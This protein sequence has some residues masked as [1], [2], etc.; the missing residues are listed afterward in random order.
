LAQGK[1]GA[2]DTI[3]SACLAGM[4]LAFHV[5]QV[6]AEAGGGVPPPLQGWLLKQKSDAGRS[7]FFSG[8]NRRYFTLDY[9]AQQLVYAH[10]EKDV[11]DT[12]SV[13]FYS[14]VGVELMQGRDSAGVDTPAEE[15]DAD[16]ATSRLV[17]QSRAT[18]SSGFRMP[19]L[20]GLSKTKQENVG[21]RLTTRDKMFE[22]FAS[23]Q[24]EADTWIR[25]LQRAVA[26]GQ[27]R[28]YEPDSL[29]KVEV[30]APPQRSP[31]VSTIASLDND[32][33]SSSTAAGESSGHASSEGEAPP[34]RA[35]AGPRPS[36]A[37]AAE[38]T[39]RHPRARDAG[40]LARVQIAQANAGLSVADSRSQANGDT[41]EALGM[42]SASIEASAA[43]WQSP[44]KGASV[45]K[46]SAKYGD[47]FQGL[48]LKERLEQMDFSD[49]EEGD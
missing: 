35:R 22:L 38:A 33:A 6:P 31:T 34:A 25:G 11:K 4:A 20:R 9:A 24:E 13:P 41:V 12:V 29:Q 49:D 40:A 10:S 37:A 14:L 3:P 27:D 7:R 23:S 1:A 39:A 16:D 26:L 2:V 18:A 17:K 47:R 15:Q 21:I 8:T 46:E 42:E 19:R 32:Q 45:A 48:S 30:T 28:V 44:T 43:A 36:R 5:Q